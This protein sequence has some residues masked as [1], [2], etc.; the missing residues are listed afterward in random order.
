MASRHPGR[1]H[2][3]GLVV[4]P[5]A[6]MGGRVGLKG[7]DGVATLERARHFGGHSEAVDRATRALQTLRTHVPNM[8]VVTWPERM[9]ES[10]ARA[11]GLNVEVLGR[12]I[13]TETTSADT[14]LAGQEILASGV[15]CL[16]FVG[17]DGTARDIMGAIHSQLPVI[18]VPAGSKMHSGVYA[19]SPR[20]AGE[21]AATFVTTPAYA[22]T[23][24][25]EV[26]DVNEDDFRNDVLS[27]SLFGYLTVPFK[28]Q[29]LQGAKGL[30]HGI[31]DAAAIEAIARGLVEGLRPGRLYL[32]GAGTATKGVFTK[33][34]LHKTLL[35]IDAVL[36]GKLVGS[37]L[38]EAGL[39]ELV[40]RHQASIVVSVIGN[41][42]F[43]FGRGNQQFS[44]EVIRQVGL[45]NIIVVATPEK[46]LALGERPLLVDTGVS[47]LDSEFTGYRMVRTGRSSHVICRVQA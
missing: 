38:S 25:A 43:I 21:L 40:S 45:D 4:N 41:Q 7:T 37:D 20:A 10:S 18:G 1:G 24:D 27:V 11:A 19:V 14:R 32:F 47:H 36:D 34:G 33:L 8:T 42:G 2:R 23:R 35:G 39:L 3:I 44:P 6:G 29:L 12:A 31:Q 16:L 5:I 15:E 28:R 17:G 22:P 46:L 30:T 13:P 26:M 9:G